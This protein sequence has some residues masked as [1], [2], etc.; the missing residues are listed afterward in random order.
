MTSQ[1]H[2][3][4]HFYAVNHDSAGFSNSAVWAHCH[5]ELT[6]QVPLLQRI[7]I[8][9][10]FLLQNVLESHGHVYTLS[11]AACQM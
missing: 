1:Q 11:C 5:V 3:S 9:I 2:R 10:Q 4:I 8:V 7:T 6:G